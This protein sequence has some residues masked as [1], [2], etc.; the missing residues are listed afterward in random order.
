MSYHLFG[1]KS[2]PKPMLTYCQSDPRYR[3]TKLFIH[4][5]AFE[6]AVCEMA[7]ILSRGD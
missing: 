5:N 4:E 2:L 1:V 6:D 3:Y 7:A